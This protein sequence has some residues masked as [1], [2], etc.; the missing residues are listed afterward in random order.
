L[1]KEGLYK[2]ES[3]TL[4]TAGTDV[5]HLMGGRMWGGDAGIYYLGTYSVRR[6]RSLPG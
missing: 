4:T 2:A 1:M 5:A 3:E 6:A